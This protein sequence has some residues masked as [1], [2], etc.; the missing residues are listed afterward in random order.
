MWEPLRKFLYGPSEGPLTLPEPP[1]DPA[2]EPPPLGDSHRRGMAAVRLLGD[3]TLAEAWAE[4]EREAYQAF[5]GSAPLD[6]AKREEAYRIVQVIALVRSR[7]IHY[8][9]VARLRQERD[10]A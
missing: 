3:P 2:L 1:Y 10:A 9:D 6:T 7:L 4:M 8:R 5:V